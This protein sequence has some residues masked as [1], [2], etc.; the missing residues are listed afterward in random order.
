MQISFHPLFVLLDFI[1]CCNHQCSVFIKRKVVVHS[2]CQPHSSE[3]SYWLRFQYQQLPLAE[4][5]ELWLVLSL[6]GISSS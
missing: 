4:Q 3:S 2:F 1:L 6:F 5:G